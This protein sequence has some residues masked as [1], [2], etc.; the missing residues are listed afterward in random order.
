[1]TN[2]FSRYFLGREPVDVSK[3]LS[4]ISDVFS[5][6]NKSENGIS[7]SA[8][9]GGNNDFPKSKSQT[10]GRDR[11]LDED[12]DDDDDQVIGVATQRVPGTRANAESDL[13]LAN[14][15]ARA[16]RRERRARRGVCVLRAI[17]VLRATMTSLLRE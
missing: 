11:N 6:T 9:S 14:A 3:V 13:S 1:M 12:D 8:R 5:G 4:S 7:D 16:H 2:P 10:E 17:R 15:A